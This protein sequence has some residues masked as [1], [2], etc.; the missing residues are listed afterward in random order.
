[1]SN[2]SWKVSRPRPIIGKRKNCAELRYLNISRSW[3]CHS[4]PP[5]SQHYAIRIRKLERRPYR[6]LKPR[7]ETFSCWGRGIF[8]IP[9]AIVKFPGNWEKVIELFIAYCTGGYQPDNPIPVC[10]CLGGRTA[11]LYLMQ[12]RLRLKKEVVATF[13]SLLHLIHIQFKR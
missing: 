4:Q 11:G 6:K 5:Y 8:W 2:L 9:K 12:K 1:M 10:V 13:N 7:I 3:T